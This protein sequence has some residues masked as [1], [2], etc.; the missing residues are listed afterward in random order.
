MGA[1]LLADKGWY[2]GVVYPKNK[3]VSNGFFIVARAQTQKNR[4]SRQ[5]AVYRG[6]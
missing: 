4:L 6:M 2:L 1:S 3:R 5:A